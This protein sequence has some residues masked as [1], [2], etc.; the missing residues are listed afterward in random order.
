ML[1]I[2]STVPLDYFLLGIDNT[3]TLRQYFRIL[4]L[5]KYYRL[6]ELIR[7]VRKHTSVDEPI[8]RISLLFILYLCTAHWFTCIQ[9]LISWSEIYKNN[10]FDG[11]TLLEFMVK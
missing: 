2:I 9:A 7:L 3:Q 10:R 1:D 6:F 11:K 4:R 5:F 8:F